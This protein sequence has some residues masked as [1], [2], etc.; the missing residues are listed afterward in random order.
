MSK[1]TR[2]ESAIRSAARQLVHDEKTHGTY[3][4]QAARSYEKLAALVGALAPPVAVAPCRCSDPFWCEE[5][6]GMPGG[7]GNT[8]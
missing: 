2:A 7:Q 5:C 3:S 6:P 1:L 4:P 8:L